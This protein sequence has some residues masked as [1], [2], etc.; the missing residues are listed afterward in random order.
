MATTIMGYIWSIWVVVKL[1]VPF[2]GTLNLRLPYYNKDPKKDH[3]FDNNSYPETKPEP[4]T[5][6]KGL[7]LAENALKKKQVAPK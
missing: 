3:H 7:K 4:K 1:M 5:Q 2:F 6:Q